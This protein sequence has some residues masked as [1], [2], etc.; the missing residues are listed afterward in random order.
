MPSGTIRSVATCQP[1]PSST[2]TTRLSGPAPTSRAKA[3]KVV[4]AK[5][6]SERKPPARAKADEMYALKRKGG[7]RPK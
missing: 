5:K 7:E 2:K 6:Y 3:R 1:A 4:E